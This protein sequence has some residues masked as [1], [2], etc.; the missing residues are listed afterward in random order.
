MSALSLS[1]II[2]KKL[3]I[4]LKKNSIFC[5]T[6]LLVEII[7]SETMYVPYQPNLTC[8]I[9]CIKKIKRGNDALFYP[10]CILLISLVHLRWD[11]SKE[12]KIHSHYFLNIPILVDIYKT[13]NLCVYQIVKDPN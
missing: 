13:R 8:D 1:L 5:I 3:S 7:E 2:S 11:S 4:D 10:K 9:L 12:K 6:H